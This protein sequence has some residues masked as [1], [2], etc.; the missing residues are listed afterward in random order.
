MC[1]NFHKFQKGL[2]LWVLSFVV[3]LLGIFK[4]GKHF[5]KGM[6]WEYIMSSWWQGRTILGAYYKKNERNVQSINLTKFVLVLRCFLRAKCFFFPFW[7]SLPICMNKKCI[8]TF[9]GSHLS[10]TLFEFS[11]TNTYLF[12]IHK[13]IV[14][15]KW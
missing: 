3:V 6:T 5:K 10:S 15:H 14:K 4:N 11:S 13:W 8:S 1:S 2:N 9:N 12:R 7:I